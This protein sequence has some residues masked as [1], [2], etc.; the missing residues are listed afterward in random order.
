MNPLPGLLAGPIT[1]VAKSAN[2]SNPLANIDASCP[3]SGPEGLPSACV[4]HSM[5]PEGNDS[6]ALTHSG[7]FGGSGGNSS[8]I[9]AEWTGWLDVLECSECHARL[10]GVEPM[11]VDPDEADGRK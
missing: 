11:T 9:D 5:G 3:H 1:S 10:I 4:G 8:C 6:D 2:G 7:G